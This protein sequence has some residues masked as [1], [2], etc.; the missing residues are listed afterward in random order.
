[1]AAPCFHCADIP[2]P[3][4]AA[5]LSRNESRHAA[6]SRRLRAGDQVVL[7]D[8]RGG[9][10]RGRIEAISN[11]GVSVS[12][13]CLERAPPP[14]PL[15]AVASAL[16]KGERF[17]TLLDM[18]GQLAVAQFIPLECSRSVVRTG[19]SAMTRGRRILLEACKQSGNPW[20]PELGEP[21]TPGAVVDAWRRTGMRVLLAHPDAGGATA[22][23][24]SAGAYGILVGPEGG[25]TERE[26]DVMVSRGAAPLSLGGNIL[27]TETVAVALVSAV[28]L[29]NGVF[30]CS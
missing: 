19:A 4:A 28:R 10:A 29:H 6:A 18:L 22:R 14:R 30:D 26:V 27:R 16:P 9:R 7:I 3:G 2:E 20:L 1:M 5:I 17:R 11:L 24:G 25:F 15:V 12:V 21:D 8:G 13:S 23:M